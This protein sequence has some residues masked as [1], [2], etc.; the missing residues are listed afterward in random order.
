MGK[1]LARAKVLGEATGEWK[2]QEGGGQQAGVS[3]KART[4]AMPGRQ[5]TAG[6]W[7]CQKDSAGV[8]G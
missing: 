2:C 7:R 4:E 3:M 8:F 6:G 1:K 5:C